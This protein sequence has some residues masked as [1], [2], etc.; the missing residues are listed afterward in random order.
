MGAGEKL[1]DLAEART[2]RLGG[3]RRR[4][5][6]AREQEELGGGAVPQQPAERFTSRERFFLGL[7]LYCKR[8]QESWQIGLR[9]HHWFSTYLNKWAAFSGF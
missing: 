5:V 6:P 7:F 9:R 3:A 2:K 8:K 1:V 4:L